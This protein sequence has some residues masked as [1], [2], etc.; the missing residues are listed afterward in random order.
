[1][2]QIDNLC[3]KIDVMFYDE[4]FYEDEDEN[5]ENTEDD[6]HS[7]FLNNLSEEEEED[8]QSMIEEHINDYLEENMIHYSE[9]NFTENLI[10]EISQQTLDYFQMHNICNEKDREYLEE[11]IEQLL[12]HVYAYNQIT[13]RHGID[14]DQD[15]PEKSLDHLM[16]AEP[17]EQRSA[18][19]YEFRH[20]LF[21]ASNIWKLFSTE[22]QYNSLVYEKCQPLKTSCDGGNFGTNNMHSAAHWGVKYEPVSAE[23]YKMKT[24]AQL[25]E[26]GCIPHPKYSFLGASPDGIVKNSPRKGRMLEIKNPVNRKITGIPSEAYWIQMQIQMEVCDLDACDFVETEFKEY[27]DETEF[28]EDQGDHEDFHKGV[29]L[30]G[31]DTCGTISPHY[32]L[33]PIQ[34]EL[35]RENIH[36]WMQ[37]KIQENTSKHHPQ[38]T[39]DLLYWK[40][41]VYSCVTILRNKIWFAFALPTIREAWST[42][43]KERRDGCEHRAPKKKIRNLMP[44]MYFDVHKLENTEDDPT[45]YAQYDGMLEDF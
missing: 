38:F 9:E 31:L 12:Q 37:T 35:N 1:M 39:Y 15:I 10:E 13:R 20:N 43:L 19:W 4:S 6:V 18:E 2:V 42:V 7:F 24:G 25:M 14:P 3:E 30:R 21:T 44:C 23:I 16:V 29:L 33:Y 36:L 40:L 34:Q 26:L 45:Q 17:H 41:N 28:W 22:C 8:L 5:D 27:N 32:E 11:Y